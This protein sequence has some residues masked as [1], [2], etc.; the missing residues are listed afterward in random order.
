MNGQYANGQGYALTG[1]SGPSGWRNLAGIGDGLTSSLEYTLHWRRKV[2]V[3]GVN[4]FG[5]GFGF[6]GARASIAVK[7]D[8]R[9][10]TIVALFADPD[11]KDVVCFGRCGIANETPGGV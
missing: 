11:D 2:D 10:G 9:S 8:Q 5:N 7:V 1:G 4:S 3:D 6:E